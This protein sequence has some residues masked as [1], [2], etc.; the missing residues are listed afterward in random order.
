MKMEKGRRRKER[1]GKK[2]STVP[3]DLLLQELK[4]LML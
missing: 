4:I 1:K 3:S 2:S